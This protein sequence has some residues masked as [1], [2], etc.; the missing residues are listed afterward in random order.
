MSKI[1]SY[2][3]QKLLELLIKK[4]KDNCDLKTKQWFDNYLKGTIEYRGLKTPQITTLVKEWHEQNNLKQYDT[5]DRLKLCSDLIANSFA[6]DK[7]AGTIYIQKYILNKIDYKIL[8]DKCNLFFQQ[9][10]FFD[11]STTDWFCTR[12]LDPIII[13]NGAIAAEIVANW[14]N[15]DNFWQR[16]ASIVSFRHPSLYREYH[17][18]IE[19]IIQR[20]VEE[21]ERFIQ[22]GIGWV[23]AD[24]SKKYP[25]EVETIFRKY[26]KQLSKEVIDRHSKYLMSHQELKKLKRSI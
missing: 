1:P 20:L 21:D 17:P 11:W 24:M 12:I 25:T 19:K 23:L 9:G 7:F 10:Y 4:L 3:R 18:F 13:N 16:R 15:S 8:L 26:I 2:Q 14:S 22:T 5:S 6:E